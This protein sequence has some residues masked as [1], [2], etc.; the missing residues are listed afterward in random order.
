M[1]NF[2]IGIIFTVAL[3]VVA[4]LLAYRA[5]EGEEEESESLRQPR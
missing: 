5:P 2:L 4:Y 1:A 3:F